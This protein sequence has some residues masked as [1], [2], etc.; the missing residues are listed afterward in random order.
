MNKIIT[1]LDAHAEAI[2]D[3]G[4]RTIKNVIEIGCQSR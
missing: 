3:L 4:K 1:A 2:R